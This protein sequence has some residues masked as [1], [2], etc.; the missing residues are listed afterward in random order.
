MKIV[1]VC[2]YVLTTLLLLFIASSCQSNTENKNFEKHH[3]DFINAS[4][5]L[6]KEYKKITIDNLVS[7][8]EENSVDNTVKNYHIQYYKKLKTTPYKFDFI[9]DTTDEGN[10][11]SF[12]SSKYFDFNKNIVSL[13]LDMLESQSY[14]IERDVGKKYERIESEYTE[15]NG[16][17]IIR[18][19]YKETYKDWIGYKTQ[20]IITTKLKTFGIIILNR[21]NIDYKNLVTE[22]KYY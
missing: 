5:F 22:M 18:V 15:N 14:A 19:K 2:N 6:P 21:N 1:K 12:Q 17:K 9:I 8:I 16:V 4:I 3:I 7:K 20:Y 11:I 13:Y 10:L